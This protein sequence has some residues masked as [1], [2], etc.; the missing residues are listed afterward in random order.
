MEKALELAG[1]ICAAAHCGCGHGVGRDCRG[2]GAQVAK[3]ADY[4]CR[5]F[6]CGA[7][8]C[9]R[10]CGTER[11]CASASNSRRAICWRPLRTSGSRLWFRIRRMCR[12]GIAIRWLLRCASMSRRWRCLPART[13]WK[14]YRR[15]IP[16]AFAVLEAGGFLAMEIG[17]GQ[18]KAIA[19]L[20]GEAGFERVEFVPDLQGIPRVVCG[21]RG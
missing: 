3:G 12:S 11:G 15:L 9:A 8:C 2:A 10:K 19:R 1:Q 18:S 13:G 4:G 5:Y 20:M 6:C 17:Y 16:A 14:L 21:R 7:G